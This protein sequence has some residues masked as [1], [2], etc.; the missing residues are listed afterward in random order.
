MKKK[1]EKKGGIPRDI[2]GGVSNSKNYSFWVFF[3]NK[4]QRKVLLKINK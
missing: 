2:L 3:F 1:K 4:N